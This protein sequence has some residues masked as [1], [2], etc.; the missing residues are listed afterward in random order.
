MGGAAGTGAAAAADTARAVAGEAGGGECRSEPPL[1]VE[2]LGS[3]T[4]DKRGPE[5]VLIKRVRVL[6]SPLRSTCV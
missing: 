6:N 2:R 5:G 3:T 4:T 1:H